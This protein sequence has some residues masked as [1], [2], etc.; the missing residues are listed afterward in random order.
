M[1]DER[2]QLGD[3]SLMVLPVIITFKK[4]NRPLKKSKETVP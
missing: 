1:D 4:G 3:G 2:K